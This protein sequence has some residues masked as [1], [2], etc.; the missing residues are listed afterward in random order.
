MYSTGVMRLNRSEVGLETFSAPFI[1]ISNLRHMLGNPLLSGCNSRDRVRI[2]KLN[3][4][5]V[6]CL[7]P[8]LYRP[9]PLPRIRK[10]RQYRQEGESSVK[11][12]NKVRD[13][14]DGE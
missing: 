14:K 6:S 3:D 2:D 12:K 13:R 8:Q 9:P 10:E 5:C 11:H 1:E 7:N 4:Q